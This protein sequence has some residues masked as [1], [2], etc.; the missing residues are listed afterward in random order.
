MNI[1]FLGGNRYFG[2][3]ILIKL[4]EKNHKVLLINRGSRGNLIKH[5]NLIFIKSDRKKIKNFENFYKNIYF[6]VIFDNIAYKLEDVK[7][8]LKVFNKKF[9]R[10]IFT[11]S[12][13]TYLSMHRFRD[14]KE[15][16]W[17]YG[18]INNEMK[19][20]FSE[21][22]LF[23]AKNKRKIEKFLL[24][25]KNIQTTIL[26]I[27]AVI[28]ENDFSKK[29]KKLLNFNYNED[30]KNNFS[31]FDKFQYVFK[32]DLVKICLKLIE[33]KNLKTNS[34]NIANKKIQ[35][36]KFYNKLRKVKRK[37]ININK[38]VNEPFPI[39]VNSF[40]ASGKI[41]KE[42]NFRFS[43]VDKV[44]KSLIKIND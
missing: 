27:P 2:K 35:I 25:K 37:T 36:G 24:K 39:P 32:D 41:K 12:A 21:F 26:R 6:D 31:K 20:S 7:S 5:K 16:D 10:Y 18:K 11:S 34:F 44:I 43:S 4:L 19:K 15:S 1:L 23:Y 28:G 3:E 22:E 13:I 40:I 42:F 29:T 8:F 14:A 9:N 30:K 17:K 33:T 38:N